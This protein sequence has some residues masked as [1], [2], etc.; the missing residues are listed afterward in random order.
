MALGAGR[1]KI[2]VGVLRRGGW[3]TAAGVTLGLFGSWGATRL[4]RSV[5]HEV[6]PTDPVTFIAVA[7][8]VAAAALLACLIP[9]RRAAR[10]D[11]MIALRAE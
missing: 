10:I 5:M 6:S 1:R 8:V 3:L 9:A 11:P 7:L 4:L 2:T